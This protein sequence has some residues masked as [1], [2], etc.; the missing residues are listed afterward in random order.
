[1]SSRAALERRGS[2][3]RLVGSQTDRRLVPR[4]G[5]QATSAR[6]DTTSMVGLLLGRATRTNSPRLAIAILGIAVAVVLSGRVAPTAGGA[7]GD[8]TPSPSWGTVDASLE[9]QVVQLVDAHRTAM[10]LGS[11]TVSKSLTASAE[12]KSLHMAAYN[13]LAHDDPA[14]PVSRTVAQ[15][16]DA[17]GYPSAAGWGENIA[18][19]YPDAA[20]VMA[21]WLGD[22]GHKANIENPS[23]TTIGV[24]VARSGSGP[25]Y[26]TQ[27]FGTTG[28]SSVPPAT[29]PQADTRS[30]TVPESASQPVTPTSG[31]SSSAS[32]PPGSSGNQPPAGQAGTQQPPAGQS[33][34][35]ETTGPSAVGPLHPTQAVLRV[36]ARTGSRAKLRWPKAPGARSGRYH[37]LLDGVS[38]LLVKGMGAALSGL[39]CGQA[40][41]VKIVPLGVSPGASSALTLV[42]AAKPCSNP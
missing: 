28:A 14:P 39:S 41:T 33:G 1:L 25:I 32:S 13:Y 36:V 26:W 38:R 6:A 34:G 18:H 5:L 21:A 4:R 37:V 24:G 19:S 3:P 22:T 29:A 7:V 35:W 11:L 20:S 30:P 27:D 16:L 40:H 17:C 31:A 8:C 10:G 9:A 42:I 15:R 12:W 2:N 23:W